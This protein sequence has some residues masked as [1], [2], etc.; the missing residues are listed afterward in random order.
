M[1]IS[2][3]DLKNTMNNSSSLNLKKQEKVNKKEDSHSLENNYTHLNIN[4]NNSS[5]IGKT[6]QKLEELNKQK[7]TPSSLEEVVVELKKDDGFTEIK[8]E[9]FKGISKMVNSDIIDNKDSEK[10]NKFLNN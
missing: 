2:S 7:V 1:E 9:Q 5:N 10:I 4:N 8:P 3:H 6:A